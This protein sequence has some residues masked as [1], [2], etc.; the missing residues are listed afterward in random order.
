MITTEL[1]VLI[2]T[3][4]GYFTPVDHVRGDVV[5][6]MIGQVEDLLRIMEQQVKYRFLSSSLLMVYEGDPSKPFKADIR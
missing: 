3:L 5:R 1:D 6:Y 2:E 4:A